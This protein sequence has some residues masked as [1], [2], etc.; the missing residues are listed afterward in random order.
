MPSLQMLGLSLF[1]S[2]KYSVI[3]PEDIERRLMEELDNTRFTTPS[4][5]G[6]QIT[7]GP[8]DKPIFFQWE[9]EGEG[10]EVG[11]F[12]RLENPVLGWKRVSSVSR[13]D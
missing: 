13:V 6:F 7:V 5:P 10:C 9:F 8:L 4:V 1:R 2:N 3:T 12:R 11:R